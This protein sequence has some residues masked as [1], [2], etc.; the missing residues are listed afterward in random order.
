MNWVSQRLNKTMSKI[1]ENIKKL[2]EIREYRVIWGAVAMAVMFAGGYYTQ[3]AI[4]TYIQL[5][6]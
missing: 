2:S 4:Q 3:N 6:K 5:S 1:K